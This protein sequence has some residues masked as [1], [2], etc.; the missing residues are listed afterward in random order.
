MHSRS[1]YFGF[2][3]LIIGVSVGL[4]EK[5][6]LLRQPS[7][8][9]A[10][11]NGV[12]APTFPYVAQITDNNVHVRSGPGTDC[13]RCGMLNKGDQVKVVSHKTVWSCIVPP[14]GSF[15][16]ISKH[17]IKID[18]AE[19]TIGTVTGDSVRVWAGSDYRKPIHSTKL[20]LKLK[21]GEK[22]RLMG[23]E[24]GDY[25]KIVPPEGAYLWVST[26]YTKAV[27]V[28]AEVLPL[29]GPPAPAAT[30]SDSNDTTGVGR[31]I[32]MS[33]EAKRLSQYRDL[34][35]QIKG[36]QQKAIGDQDYRSIKKALAEIAGDKEA[37]KAARYCQFVLKQIERYE[38][39]LKV[40][41]AVRLQDKQ[42][43][44]I[45][46]RIDKART[47]RL[48]EVQKLDLGRFAVVGRFETSTVYS[49]EKQLKRYRITDDSGKTV[50]YAAA[51]GAASNMDLSKF[52]GRKVGLVG[53][54]QANQEMREVLV[55][56]SELT[57]LKQ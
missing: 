1:I 16:W 42:L 10:D 43:H 25:Y 7:S 49:P 15:S 32:D 34:Q 54:I 57:E 40:H 14:P 23:E 12:E 30:V 51:T 9:I 56:F 33:T 5:P 37:G 24:I 8:A 36:E 6:V 3:L 50:C 21:K 35:K 26:S 11:A 17:Y 46:E 29:Y 52:V 13:Y 19:A 47:T 38:L 20:Q 18:L 55:R 22:V 44:E 48:A 39:A 2:V 28:T 4:G 31:P 45:Q 53:T 27:T 41:K